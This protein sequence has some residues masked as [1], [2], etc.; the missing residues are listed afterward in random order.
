MMA[1]SGQAQQ[2]TSAP[3]IV[4]QNMAP[5]PMMQGLGAMVPGAMGQAPQGMPHKVMLRNN[6]LPMPQQ[7]MQAA[8]GG[9]AGMPTPDEEY[10]AKAVLLRF[11]QVV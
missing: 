8:S 11:N 2:P 5:N 3:S 7:P 9:L 4:A 6:E 1:M 10:A